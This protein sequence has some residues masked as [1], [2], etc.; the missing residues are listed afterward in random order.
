MSVAQQCGWKIQPSRGQGN[1]GL[2]AGGSC[3]AALSAQ[4]LNALELHARDDGP[5]VNGFVQRRTDSQ[6]VHAVLNFADQLIRDALLHQQPRAGAANLSLVEPDAVDEALDGA[7]EIGVF[8]NDERRL[9]AKFEGKLFMALRGDLSNHPPH[10]RRAR[11][12]NL[13]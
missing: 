5:N 10:F 3:A 13:S 2:P 11:K 12:T 7:V 1:G 8:K 6:G 9:T 4:P